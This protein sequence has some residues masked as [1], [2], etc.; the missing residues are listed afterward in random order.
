MSPFQKVIVIGLDGLESSVV[1]RL[2]A[3]GQLPNLDK[4]RHRGGY[5]TV[6]TTSPAQTPVAW[7]S[8]AT[9]TNPGG[10]GV[11]DF[12]RRNPKNYLPDFALN[13]YEQKNAFTPP[14]AVNLRRGK[15]FW[16][17]LGAAGIPSA[18]LRL[19]CTYPPD[20]LNG[21]MLAGMGVPDLRGGLGTSTFYSSAADVAARESENAV[22]IQPDGAGVFGTYLIGPRN[23]KAQS[24]YRTDIQVTPQWERRR[25]EIRSDGTPQM[26]HVG[27]GEWSDWLKVRFKTGLLQSVRGMV[28]FY[29]ARLE[30]RLELY[31]SP[32]N[33]DPDTP[34]FPISHPPE[35]AAEL[36]R[37]TGTFY[38]T[39]MVEDHGGLNNE[40]IDEAAYLMQCQQV[41]AERERLL[42]FEL[43]RLDRGFLFCL[44][45]TPDRLQHMF[46]RYGEPDHPAHRGAPPVG[47]LGPVIDR[48]YAECDALIGRVLESVD[49]R[50]MLIVLSDHG[51]TTFR[52]GVNLNTWLH[53]Q[54]LLA[55]RD[56]MRP[57]EAAGDFFHH[58]DWDRTQAYALGLTGI[59]L[60][61]RGREERGT[62]DAG[63]ALALRERIAA[64][65][66]GFRD[67]DGGGV[68]IRTV[69]PREQVYR[70]PYVE[71]APDLVV[72]Y[73]RGYRVSWSTA[74]G[75]IPDT[76]VEDNRK[77]WS[78]DHIIDPALV[79]GVLFCNRALRQDGPA[80]VDLAP[81]ILAAFGLPADV[82]MEGKSLLP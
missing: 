60:N 42:R 77:K 58:V 25:V 61:Q 50:T 48:H 12:I 13:R 43:D 18:I 46:W 81:T 76:L 44:F 27:L 28:R 21:R 62:V 70:G 41:M 9:G 14:R 67:P 5:Q 17:T 39:G 45:D 29:L 59:Y 31:A 24:D 34:L 73:A 20:A 36:A 69:I 1:D 57:G 68:A 6:R 32:V 3:A 74:L 40:R 2:L 55:L 66:S 63:A 71:E 56:G 15:P 49:D 10:H 82:V 78:G 8:F 35:Y 22:H 4:L 64:G 80:L 47:D 19:P 37:K 53:A 79:P 16:E 30:P 75:G 23:A 26:L 7:S 33:F 65:L 54:G 72:N 38:T 11:F 51:M 52:R